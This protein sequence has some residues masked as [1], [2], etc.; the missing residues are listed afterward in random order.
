MIDLLREASIKDGFIVHDGEPVTSERIKKII[1]V[2]LMEQD[3]V[4]QHTII[5]G[6]VQA[7]DPQ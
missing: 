6:G 5:A 7:C 1:N 4:S 3:C 2:G